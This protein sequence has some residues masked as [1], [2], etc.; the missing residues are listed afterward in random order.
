MG[1]RGEWFSDNFILIDRSFG[2]KFNIVLKKINLY[3]IYWNNNNN[4]NVI[5]ALDFFHLFCAT[6]VLLAFCLGWELIWRHSLLSLS[7]L[8]LTIREPYVIYISRT[9]GVAT[10][11][12]P[13]NVQ[14]IR[15]TN[16]LF[17]SSYNKISI[18]FPVLAKILLIQSQCYSASAWPQPTTYQISIHKYFFHCL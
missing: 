2:S 7:I 3:L 18:E 10:M 8:I 13:W 17:S 4:N 9:W 16:L 1:V 11:N 6:E 5:F 14:N 12:C 15:I